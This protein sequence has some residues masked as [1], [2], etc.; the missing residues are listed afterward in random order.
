MDLRRRVVEAYDSGLSGTYAQTAE[1]FGVGQ[2]TVNRWLRRKRETG[3][4]KPLPRKGNNPR[5]VD[6][7]WLR[8]HAVQNPDARLID[9]VEAWE[10][11]GGVRVH[12]DTM[13]ASM[14]AIGWTYKKKRQWQG[15]ASART[16]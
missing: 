10:A 4:V 6:L 7:D 15:S 9:R 16:S 14:R 3:D 1:L 2:A 11:H 12:I 5:R 8:E 13:S